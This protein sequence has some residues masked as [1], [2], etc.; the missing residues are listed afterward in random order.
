MS[1]PTPQVYFSVCGH[2]FV[3]WFGYVLK[4]P[5]VPRTINM[6]YGVE[7]QIVLVGYTL[8]VCQLFAQLAARGASVL[9]LGSPGRSLRCRHLLRMWRVLYAS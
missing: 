4:Q 9:Y 6:T 2:P 1:Y 7:E 8:G 5:E 3:N